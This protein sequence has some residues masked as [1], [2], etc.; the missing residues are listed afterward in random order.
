M[1]LS[2][3]NQNQ[4]SPW[5]LAWV[6]VPA[7]SIALWLQEKAAVP[8]YGSQ[9]VLLSSISPVLLYFTVVLLK[10]PTAPALAY[11]TGPASA[12]L[13]RPLPNWHLPLITQHYAQHLLRTQ[14]FGL[15]LSL[16]TLGYVIYH[17]STT[18][19][20]S[21]IYTPSVTRAWDFPLL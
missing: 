12:L 5:A 10:L 6:L 20:V 14:R 9:S 4:V 8:W 11:H 21:V 13:G 7:P 16:F 2:E 19:V 3:L 17:P 15:F 1:L 18:E